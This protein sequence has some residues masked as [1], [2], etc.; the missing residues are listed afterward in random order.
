V[1]LAVL[2]LAPP[3]PA[4]HLE[5]FQS[6]VE[7][8]SNPGTP[9]KVELGKILFFDRRLSGDGTMSCAT[10]HI[11]DLGFGDGQA[12]GLNYPTTKNWRN[13]QTLI[14]VAYQKFFFHDGRV[15]SLEDQALFPIMS[16]F[17]MN[18]NLDYLE[19]EI[20][21][22]PEY[23]ERFRQV[24]GSEDVTRERI[25]MAIAAFERTL[26]S[27]NAPLD[28]YLDGDDG[29]L[30]PAAKRGLEVFTGKGKCADCHYG[31][32]LIDSRFHA[33]NVPEHP[34][35]QQDPRVAATRRFVAKVN[36]FE[37]FRS[38]EEDPGRYLI[39]KRDEDWRAFRTPTL[40]DISNTGPYMHNGIFETLEET[41]EFLD[42]GEAKSLAPLGLTAEE[43]ADLVLFLEEGLTGEKLAVRPP[44]I[45]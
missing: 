15:E 42:L 20:R 2:L 21:S 1:V 31:T 23:L 29:A 11:P 38:L 44:R 41:I 6:A 25:A 37:K 40:R 45:P 8:A 13:T 14:N 4:G 36:H 9:E 35:F 22:V 26:V 19:E 24:F 27:R 33:L 7:P 16:A 43:K 34:D 18:Q 32:A 17:E 12:I 10:C 39:T 3:V 28:R 30:T 5:P